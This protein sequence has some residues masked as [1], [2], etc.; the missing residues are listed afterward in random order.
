MGPNFSANC[1]LELTAIITMNPDNVIPNASTLGRRVIKAATSVASREIVKSLRREKK[2]K[3]KQQ[4]LGEGKPTKAPGEVPQ[5]IEIISHK[6]AP[7]EVSH[8]DDATSQRPTAYVTPGRLLRRMK[9]KFPCDTKVTSDHWG[10]REHGEVIYNSIVRNH[11]DLLCG[12]VDY[13]LGPNKKVDISDLY[14]Y[15]QAITTEG[16]WSDKEAALASVLIP[17]VGFGSKPIS[18]LDNAESLLAYIYIANVLFPRAIRAKCLKVLLTYNPEIPEGCNYK[19]LLLTKLTAICRKR[20]G[21]DATR[22]GYYI[23]LWSSF[24]MRVSLRQHLEDVSR[25][26]TICYPSFSLASFSG[27]HVVY[28]KTGQ[29]ILHFPNTYEVPAGVTLTTARLIGL[30]MLFYTPIQ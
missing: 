10:L 25:E 4:H 15:G 22:L 1:A 29:L 3:R 20:F 16:V 21:R 14:G 13:S 28:S 12:G 18:K 30:P 5:G 27:R 9:N 23:N 11:L 2:K 17:L 19:F 6:V 7:K 26:E 8:A 24:I